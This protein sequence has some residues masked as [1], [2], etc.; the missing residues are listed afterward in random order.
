MVDRQQQK[1]KTNEVIFLA[2]VDFPGLF[3][4][5]WFWEHTRGD[6]SWRVEVG[7]M[8][9]ADQVQLTTHFAAENIGYPPACSRRHVAWTGHCT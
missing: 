1:S 6:P 3:Q 9:G 7:G 8:H 4:V 5:F 2:A